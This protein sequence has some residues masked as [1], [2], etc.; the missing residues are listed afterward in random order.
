MT[1]NGTFT[2]ETSRIVFEGDTASIDGVGTNNFA[3][4]QIDTLT[5][6]NLNTDINVLSDFINDG[7]FVSDGFTVVFSGTDAGT[8][9]G[10]KG[11]VTF[12]LLETTK[13]GWCSNNAFYSCYNR[14]S[15]DHDIWIFQHRCYKPDHRI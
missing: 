11:S 3:D 2:G 9:S 13:T 5:N 4:I 14:R 15:F 8:I 6:F 1:N 10:K 7:E 12:D